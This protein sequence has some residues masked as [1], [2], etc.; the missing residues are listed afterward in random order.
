MK[1]DSERAFDNCDFGCDR[2]KNLVSKESR[3]DDEN[4][5]KQSMNDIPE[6]PIDSEDNGEIESHL[7]NKKVSDGDDEN[8]NKLP[9]ET[10]PIGKSLVF[11][12]I[13]DSRTTNNEWIFA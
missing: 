5:Q 13:L 1:S 9:R 2:N 11:Y 10:S 3:V 8:N 7:S 6:C 4:R 12:S